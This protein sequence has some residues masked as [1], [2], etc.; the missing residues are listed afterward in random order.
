MGDGARTFA[1]SFAFQRPLDTWARWFA[2]VPTRS[3]VRVDD[4][5][6]E[7]VYGLWRVAT[8]W[9]NVVGV[10]R[11]GPY[12]AWKVA[13]PAQLSW[14][15]RGSRWLPRPPVAPAFG[16]VSRSPASSRSASSATLQ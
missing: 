14:A 4:H 10:E 1:F 7:A 11:T 9:E 3:Y 15:D 16:S 13:G 6:F 8:V 2:V 5:G 12:R